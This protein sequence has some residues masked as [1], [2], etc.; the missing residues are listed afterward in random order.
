MISRMKCIL[1]I[2]ILL[3]A[4]LTQADQ[5]FFETWLVKDGTVAENGWEAYS[6][7]SASDVSNT[8]AN[9]ND[10]SIWSGNGGDALGSYL[11]TGNNIN[12]TDTF[13][14]TNKADPLAINVADI[15]DIS[16][17]D[18]FDSGS[19]SGWI[20][21]LE[22]DNQWY[23][24]VTDGGHTNTS[25]GDEPFVFST[26]AANWYSFDFTAGST[27]DISGTTNPVSDLS[28]TV[29]GIGFLLAAQ[30]NSADTAR[31]DTISISYVPEPSTLTLLALAALSIIGVRR[32]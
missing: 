22:V 2:I 30:T 16:Y 11:F 4:S 21:A 1:P 18:R 25:F 7:S 24:S 28:G 9:S 19:D 5:I 13:I 17:S 8:N 26:A 6:T 15:T 10:I 29:T 31:I 27:L 23:R 12:Q 14:L 20:V 32:R 3:T